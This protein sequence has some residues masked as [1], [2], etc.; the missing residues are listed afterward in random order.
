MRASFIF[1]SFSLFVTALFAGP[2]TKIACIGDSITYGYGLAN[3][4]KETYPARLQVLLDE[5]FPGKY[6]VRNFGSSGRGIYLDSWRGRE[7]RGFR[8]MPEHK[9][10]LAWKPL[11]VLG[12][13]RATLMYSTSL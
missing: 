12:R 9:T 13:T 7:R 10:A 2:K 8:Y 1:F 4:A 3:R 11:D 6:E 5:R